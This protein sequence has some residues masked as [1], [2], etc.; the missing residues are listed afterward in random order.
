MNPNEPKLP[1]PPRSPWFVHRDG[2]AFRVD[3]AH[4]YEAIDRTG[5]EWVKGRGYQRRRECVELDA[6]DSRLLLDSLLYAMADIVGVA[7]DGMPVGSLAAQDAR[8]WVCVWQQRDVDG[9]VHV[10]L[11]DVVDLVTAREAVD[12]TRRVL[13]E[14]RARCEAGIVKHKGEPI[15][16]ARVKSGPRK[17]E[18]KWPRSEAARAELLTTV[19]NNRHLAAEL[20]AAEQMAADAGGLLAELV[21]AELYSRP[22]TKWSD[23]ELEAELDRL[24]REQR[25]DRLRSDALHNVETEHGR[26]L[27]VR[28]HGFDVGARVLYSMPIYGL[29]GLERREPRRATVVEVRYEPTSRGYFGDDPTRMHVRVV[30]LDEPYTDALSGETTS[31]RGCVATDLQPL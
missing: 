24:R 15:D 13:A 11:R 7:V 22:K 12:E 17:G 6:N 30:R 27:T 29:A 3:A 19:A 16:F 25:S 20:A 2:S 1:D 21:A 5:W 14:V 28:E 9:C 23:A 31:V 4:L 10:W 18:V 26:R 8:P